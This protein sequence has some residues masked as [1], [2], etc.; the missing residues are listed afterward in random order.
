MCYPLSQ[1]LLWL[2][3]RVRAGAALSVRRF[4]QLRTARALLAGDQPAETAH[5]GAVA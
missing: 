2:E 1:A 3:R 5:A 4:R